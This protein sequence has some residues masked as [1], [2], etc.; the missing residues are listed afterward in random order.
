MWL[1]DPQECIEQA[2]KLHGS[3][4]A[5]KNYGLEQERRLRRKWD[6]LTYGN[7]FKKIWYPVIVLRSDPPPYN[8]LFMNIVV[9]PWIT[10]GGIAWG[11]PVG[12]V[13]SMNMISDTDSVGTWKRPY[14]NHCRKS[15]VTTADLKECEC[16][17]EISVKE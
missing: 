15:Q 4:M 5:L 14:D 2:V 17:T 7:G 6:V 1:F 11:S 12:I 9:A 10:A 13:T 8:R 16:I 3:R